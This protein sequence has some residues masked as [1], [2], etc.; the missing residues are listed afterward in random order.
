MSVFTSHWKHVQ[1]PRV[2]GSALSGQLLLRLLPDLRR[3]S[4]QIVQK[5]S[6]AWKQMGG[7]HKNGASMSIAF[8]W[9]MLV[10][11]ATWT[12]LPLYSVRL[13]NTPVQHTSQE[14]RAVVG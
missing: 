12:S 10:K 9:Q 14:A 11:W 7:W 2:F 8:P 6:S 5:W 4:K 3:F 1:H 13:R